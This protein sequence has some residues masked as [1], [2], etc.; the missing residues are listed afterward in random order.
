MNQMKK[1]KLT[2]LFALL[3]VLL[4]GNS[5]YS[6]P[7]GARN[8]ITRTQCLSGL[9]GCSDDTIILKLS[10]AA[11]GSTQAT[12]TK[13]DIQTYPINETRIKVIIGTLSSTGTYTL[14]TTVGGQVS[15]NATDGISPYSVLITKTADGQFKLEVSDFPF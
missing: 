8:T 4:F 3:C 7:P 14:P 6:Q 10:S 13:N 12:F 2:A 5:A 11:I 9:S 1:M 15:V